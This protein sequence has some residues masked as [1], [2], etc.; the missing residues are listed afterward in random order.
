MKPF[1][2]QD[3]RALLEHRVQIYWLAHKQLVASPVHTIRMHKQENCVPR[4]TSCFAQEQLV[5][6]GT[7][8]LL[9]AVVR[10]RDR[11]SFAACCGT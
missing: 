9:L 7:G 10:D 6:T 11:P 4:G 1:F 3:G 8:H 2:G 5:G